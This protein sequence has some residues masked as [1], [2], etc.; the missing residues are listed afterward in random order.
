M[1]KLYLAFILLTIC[2]SALAEPSE[3]FYVNDDKNLALKSEPHGYASTLKVLPT[4]SSVTAI[5]KPYNGYIKVRSP[6][7]TEG[8]IK[9]IYVRKEPPA[10]NANDTASKTI[11]TLQAKI[12]ALEDELK[13]TKEK[14]TPGTSLEKTLSSERDQLAQ[15]L[16][17]LKAT[18]KNAVQIKQER[19]LLQ[20][21]HVNAT[22]D[23]EQCKIDKAALE[24]TTKQDWMLYGGALVIIG[25]FLGFIL[26]KISWRR[27]SSW[28]SY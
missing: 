28:D 4:G 26:P 9:S 18:A 13:V 21:Q 2:G 8:Y 3:I 23:F 7:G 24:D 16:N 5:A 15:D 11:A 27:R 20:E 1:K 25:V 17:E 12:S 22:R 14:I 10:Q 19:D 6:D